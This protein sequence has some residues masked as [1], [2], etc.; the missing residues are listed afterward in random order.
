MSQ[1]THRNPTFRRTQIMVANLIRLTIEKGS[2]TGI[3]SSLS[4]VAARLTPPA[5]FS[6][7]RSAQPYPLVCVPWPDFLWTAHVHLAKV[8]C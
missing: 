3:P 2:V 4:T 1:L 5:H 7:C 6:C 8:V